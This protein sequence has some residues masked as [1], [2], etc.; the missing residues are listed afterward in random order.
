MY[1][2]SLCCDDVNAIQYPP[3]AHEM[4]GPFNMGGLNGFHFTGVTGMNAFAGHVPEDGA[5]YVFYV[6]H[7]GITAI[8][9]IG[10]IHRIGQCSNSACC[11]AAQ[12]ALAKLQQGEIQEGNLTELDYR[13]NTIE[14][15]FLW[16]NFLDD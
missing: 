10:E 14:Q 6:P 11:G 4:L 12:G 9:T 5:V 13:M 15:I 3:R 8:G 7:T 2:D 16:R 1:A